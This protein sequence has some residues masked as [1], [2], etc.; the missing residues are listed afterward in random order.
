[1][2]IRDSNRTRLNMTDIQWMSWPE[3][4]R[5]KEQRKKKE[6]LCPANLMLRGKQVWS[7]STTNATVTPIL[8]VKVVSIQFSVS[9]CVPQWFI[10]YIWKLPTDTEMTKWSLCP[11]Q[12]ETKLIKIIIYE[13]V[14]NVPFWHHHKEFKNLT[15]LY[16]V[17]YSWF[18]THS[19]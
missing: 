10:R 6:Y 4:G 13:F 18:H 1:M 15:C 7:I 2:C 8:L 14:S 3:P 9:I 19:L 16:L 17:D 12:Y 11:K 5:Y